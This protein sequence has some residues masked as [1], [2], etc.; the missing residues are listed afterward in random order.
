MPII[1]ARSVLKGGEREWYAVAG[2][3]HE[4]CFKSRTLSRL[5]APRSPAAVMR[6]SMRWHYA[7]ELLRCLL[8]DYLKSPRMPVFRPLRAYDQ[9]CSSSLRF[10]APRRPVLTFKALREDAYR[11]ALKNLPSFVCLWNALYR[12]TGDA[13]L[14]R[15]L[16]L[17]PPDVHT[18]RVYPSSFSD[19]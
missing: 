19:G 12:I 13:S 17:V 5:W 16:G 2:A 11:K 15:A 7:C 10:G 1:L 14:A 9:A 6:P 8:H 3:R 4:N 18:G